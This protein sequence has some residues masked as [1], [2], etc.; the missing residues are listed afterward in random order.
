MNIEEIIT[1]LTVIELKSISAA[2]NKLFISQS[3]ASKRIHNLETA[4]G[5]TLIHR[6]K[7]I[8]EISLTAKGEYFLPMAQQWFALYQDVQNLKQ[9]DFIYTLKIAT[10]NILNTYLL[11]YIFSSFSNKYPNIMI[12]S[13]NEHSTQAYQSVANQLSDIAIEFTQHYDPNVISKPLFKEQMVFICHKNSKFA[14]T[15]QICDLVDFHEVYAKWSNDFE[16]WHQRCFPYT[17]R[18]KIIV[19]SSTMIEQFLNEP[20]DWCL[21]SRLVAESIHLNKPDYI[22]IHSNQLPIR[23]AYYMTHKYPKPGSKKLVQLFLSELFLHITHNPYIE[24]IQ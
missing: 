12:Q 5:V 7:G 16:T 24:M 13:Q 8:K 14:K 11:P 9:S 4:L 18:Y 3:T 21:A 22:I 10:N 1:F 19:G 15:K 6:A 23:T 2:A 17:R 20:E